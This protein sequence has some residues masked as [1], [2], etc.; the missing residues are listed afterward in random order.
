MSERK[1]PEQTDIQRRGILQGAGGR[2]LRTPEDFQRTPA[3]FKL[4][5]DESGAVNRWNMTIYRFRGDRIVA[6]EI[7]S[8][9]GNDAPSS[10]YR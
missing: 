9:W 2:T 10:A 5:I 7:K 3:M 1:H 6:T 8:G 4:T